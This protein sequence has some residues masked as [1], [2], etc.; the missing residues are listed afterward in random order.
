M[1][2]RP[3]LYARL[4]SP[5]LFRCILRCSTSEDSQPLHLHWGSCFLCLNS[6][7]QTMLNPCVFHDIFWSHFSF[8]FSFTML[9][10]HTIYPP[11][12]PTYCCHCLQPWQ[13]PKT[14][15]GLQQVNIRPDNHSEP[16]LHCA[17]LDLDLGQDTSRPPHSMSQTIT[18][19]GCSHC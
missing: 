8:Y 19:H 15:Q 1:Y 13:Q 4:T 12:H 16:D 17:M 3:L 11:F 10:S 9:S 5:C 14:I 7:K 6:G 2:L 18:M